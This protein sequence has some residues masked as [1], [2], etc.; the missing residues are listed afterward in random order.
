MIRHNDIDKDTLRDKIKHLSIRCAGH[1]KLKIYGK[2]NCAYGKRMKHENRVFFASEK[3][4]I[5]KG[6]RPC[7][8]CMRD[9][10]KQWISLNK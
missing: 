3:E 4:A 7:G 9:K 10:Y 6:F 8:H 1:A 2:L 5:A